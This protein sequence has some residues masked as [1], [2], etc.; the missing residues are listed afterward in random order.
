VRHGDFALPFGYEAMRSILEL[1]PSQRPT[2]VF[3]RPTSSP[4]GPTRPP[5]KRDSACHGTSPWWVS[6]TSRP[7]R[8]RT[9]P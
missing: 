2:A 4:S 8:P 6:T 3:G 9:R 7:P 1:P 5:T